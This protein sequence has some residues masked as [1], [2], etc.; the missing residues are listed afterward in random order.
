[1]KCDITLEVTKFFGQVNV[2]NLLPG[3]VGRLP[4]L[5]PCRCWLAGLVIMHIFAHICV[6]HSGERQGRGGMAFFAVGHAGSSDRMG[7]W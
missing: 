2:P 3:V 4:L 7:K 1:M 5:L 6:H